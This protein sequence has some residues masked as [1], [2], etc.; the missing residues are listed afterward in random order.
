[1]KDYCDTL[2][3]FSFSWFFVC[4]DSRKLK[5]VEVVSMETVKSNRKEKTIG[6][7]EQRRA[8]L[9]G[10]LAALEKNISTKKRNDDNR[11]KILVGAMYLKKAEEDAGIKTKL[12]TAL[13]NYLT[14]DYDRILF[15]LP[16]PETP[17]TSGSEIIEVL[18]PV[19]DTG[20]K[21]TGNK[22]KGKQPGEI[23]EAEK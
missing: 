23:E 5:L 7:L 4:Y 9:Q 10:K 18:R 22:T 17:I 1:M 3:R 6:E 2:T 11:R 13:D 20:N 12:W 15:D 21:G 19:D 14:K 8:A 16:T